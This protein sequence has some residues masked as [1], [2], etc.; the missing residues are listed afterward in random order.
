MPSACSSPHD[1]NPPIPVKKAP[2]PG[3]LSGLVINCRKITNKLVEFWNILE[4]AKPSIVILTETWL[5]PNISNH[6]IFPPALDYEVYRR[7]RPDGWGGVAIGIGPGI[8]GKLL[9]E[10]KDCEAIF[11]EIDLKQNGTHRHRGESESLIIGAAYRPPSSSAEYMDCLSNVIQDVANKNKKSILW[12][13]GDFNLPDIDWKTFSIVGHQYPRVINESII[14]TM[15]EAGLDQVVTF[16]TRLDNTLDLF[17][18]NRPSCI[19]KCQ[20]IPG[21]SDHE[22]VYIDSDIKPRRKRPVKRKIYL[23]DKAD[24]NVI[25]DEGN[26]MMQEFVSTYDSSSS[27]IEMWDSI[28]S[29][30]MKI[31]DLVPSKFT[32]TRFNQ[33]WVTRKVKQL[34]RQK[35]RAYNKACSCHRQHKKRL[36]A[37]YNLLKKKMQRVCKE[38][39]TNYINTI[40]CPDL[41]SNPKRFWSHISSKRCDNN[42]VAPLRGPR[43]AI[44]TGSKDKANILNQQFCSVFNKEED[45][46]SLPDLGSSSFP[47]IGHIEVTTNGVIKLLKKINPHKATGPDNIPARL[48]KELADSLGPMLTI[49]YQASL[50]SGILPTIWKAATVAPIFKKGD[51]NKP[52]NYRPISLTVIC[53][54]L[55]EHIIH[56]SMMRHFDSCNILT[57]FQHGFRKARSC[58]SQLIITVDDI[59]NNLDDGLQ[60]DLILLDFSKAFDKVPHLHLLH[61]LQHY[62]I[63]GSLLT[64]IS[65]FLQGRVQK[66]NLDGESSD[67]SPVSSGVPTG[68]GPRPTSI[69]GLH[70]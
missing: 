65:N 52:S 19:N 48:L 64:W 23:W 3:N 42:G 18:T 57:D 21:I 2:L 39:Y 47:S 46:S 37:R 28:E 14:T 44:Y 15:T 7:D 32:S 6:E 22:I 45:S 60:T 12:V 5:N 43:G 63:K 53:C 9:H 40:I 11:I 58:E 8:D 13:G 69:L 10:A 27:V 67:Q 33:P 70:Q 1:E 59:A 66:V 62:G 29:K 54:K 38:A 51:R 68:Y 4:T 35:Q 55:L 34:N 20:P 36:W 24:M 61:K 25:H 41:Q 17:L 56:S 31:L 50:D 26:K 30:L 49:L 16:P